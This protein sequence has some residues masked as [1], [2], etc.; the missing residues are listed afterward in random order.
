VGED[1][2]LRS[3]SMFLIIELSA[4]NGNLGHALSSRRTNR[5]QLTPSLP[6]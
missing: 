2:S 1:D 4:I 3:S 6:A 5:F